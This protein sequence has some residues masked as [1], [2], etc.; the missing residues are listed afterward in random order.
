[1]RDPEATQILIDKAKGGDRAAFDDL[2]ERFRS[3]LRSRLE[4]WS[5]FQLG[6]RLDVEDV[7][8]GIFLRAFRAIDHFEWQDD[9]AFFRWLCGIAKRALADEARASWRETLKKAEAIPDGFPVSG[10]TPSRI[11]RREE[12]LHRLERA[13]QKLNP[14]YRQ[15]LL[16]S[17]IEGLTMKEIG[18]RLGRSTDSVKHLIARGLRELKKQFGDTE[19]F[20][21]A[22][23]PLEVEGEKH[24][25]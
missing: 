18:E 17:R 19:S 7:L 10:P 13:L 23:R 2:I 20:H 22:D 24:G 21:L 4:S 25:E 5:Q 3:R 6:P 14:D 12:R 9:D 8:Q 11:L 15:A 1:M 16:L